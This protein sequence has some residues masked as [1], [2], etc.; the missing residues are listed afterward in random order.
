MVRDLCCAEPAKKVLMQHGRFDTVDQVRHCRILFCKS[1][2]ERL[3][4][5]AMNKLKK[6]IKKRITLK[7]RS[8][9][10]LSLIQY[11]SFIF[12]VRK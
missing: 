6:S 2:T 9:F 3:I 8:G 10:R 11:G 5:R 1:L 4:L 12:S 7:Y